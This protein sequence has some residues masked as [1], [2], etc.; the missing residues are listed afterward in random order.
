MARRGENRLGWG[1]APA[2][3]L[4]PCVPS[5]DV[6]HALSESA[7]ETIDSQPCYREGM[8]NTRVSGPCRC[9]ATNP[10]LLPA[11]S[12]TACDGHTPGRFAVCECGGH[13]YADAGSGD[14]AWVCYNPQDPDSSIWDRDV[15]GPHEARADESGELALYFLNDDA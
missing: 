5:W 12:Y 14:P 4:S 7:D 9:G 8:T 13:L 6:G 1:V 2:V 15:D 11:H 10:P 3:V